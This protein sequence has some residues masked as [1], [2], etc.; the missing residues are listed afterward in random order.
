MEMIFDVAF[1]VSSRHIRVLVDTDIYPPPPPNS[2][3]SKPTSRLRCNG[4]RC[5]GAHMQVSRIPERQDA[6]RREA[7]H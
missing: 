2:H 7:K 6:C 5:K 3:L 4:A 1:R